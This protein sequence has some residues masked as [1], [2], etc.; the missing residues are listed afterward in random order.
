MA[1]LIGAVGYGVTFSGMLV[2]FLISSLEVEW[3]DSKTSMGN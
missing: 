1:I 3:N 2:A